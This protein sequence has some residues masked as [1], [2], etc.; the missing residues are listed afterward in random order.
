MKKL[1]MP[2]IFAT[3][4][5]LIV[6]APAMAGQKQKQEGPRQYQEC[7]QRAGDK[8]EQQKICDE[9]LKQFQAGQQKQAEETWSQVLKGPKQ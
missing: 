6:T 9:G 3:A 8:A 4:V 2:I 1:V 7:V 5:T